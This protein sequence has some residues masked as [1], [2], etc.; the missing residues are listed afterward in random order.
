MCTRYDGVMRIWFNGQIMDEAEARVS[1]FDRGFLFG[2]GVYEGIRFFNR[3]GVGMDLHVSRLAKSLEG[4]GIGGFEATDL[5]EICA[6]LLEDG[7]LDDA[8]IYFQITRGV[9]IPRN[10]HPNP[11]MTPTVFAYATPAPALHELDRPNVKT[12]ITTED[13]RWRHC[14]IKCISLLAN[15]LG[16]GEARDREYDESIFVRDGFVGE[17]A[18]TNVFVAI[19]G[20][21]ITPTT[22]ED[23]P[24][25]H[26]VTR[27][28]LLEVAPHVV[29]RV[30]VR[31]L[32]I[33]EL[34]N[35]D[36][37]MIT[38]SRRLL[39]SVRLVDDQAIDAAPGPVAIALLAKLKVHLAET[40][41][42][43]LH[44]S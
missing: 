41:D 29:E 31:R 38:S 20:T 12:C 26:G 37:V 9:Q 40:S 30:E 39:D 32:S 42:I 13:I 7:R 10:H 16:I 25:L 2:D 43:A 35:A 15:I 27:T 5:H 1:P 17:G 23:P 44:S 34:R 14:E 21:L 11:S 36:E 22:N 24:I 3:V 28:L 19:D 6:A 4:T 18:M 8:M 33:E